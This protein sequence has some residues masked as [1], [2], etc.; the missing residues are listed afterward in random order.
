[1]LLSQS[2]SLSMWR[3]KDKG[4][5]WSHIL[6][7]VSYTGRTRQWHPSLYLVA[8]YCLGGPES[9][10]PGDFVVNGIAPG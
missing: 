10:K 2:L 5:A 8:C 3:R 1:M 7:V 4:A 6:D 9:G